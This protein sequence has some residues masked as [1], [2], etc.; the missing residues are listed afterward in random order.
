MKGS[1][2]FTKVLLIIALFIH[3]SVFY[4]SPIRFEIWDQIIIGNSSLDSINLDFENFGAHTIRIFIIN[5]II[6]I[7]DL[8][9]YSP[10]ISFNIFLNIL[11]LG[12]VFLLLKILSS[13]R[14][15]RIELSTV[16]LLPII[17]SQFQ[18]GRGVI[19][20]FAFLLLYYSFVR[21]ASYNKDILKFIVSLIICIAL[22]NMSSGSF[23]V[24][25]LACIAYLHRAWLKRKEQSM[26][27]SN[28]SLFI[29]ILS[30]T[31][32]SPLVVIYL[33]KNLDFYEGSMF[34]ML[35]HGIWSILSSLNFIFLL[36]S[37]IILLPI[38]L[39]VRIALIRIR[40]LSSLV[41]FLN[42]GFVGLFFGFTAFFTGIY[43]YIIFSFLLFNNVLLKKYN[44]KPNSKK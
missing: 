15:N 20:S 21:Y 16:S 3:S 38:F 23:M 41:P 36:L 17:I 35:H 4:L 33:S 13:F 39:L 7:G 18:N 24:G 40:N 29:L 25:L 19:T 34:K 14:V 8:F 31:L 27:I 26:K 32:T 22:L 10:Q 1:I 11:L 37:I 42:A 44:F 12:C 2:S 9:S 30:F 28:L 43:L 5:V 6:I